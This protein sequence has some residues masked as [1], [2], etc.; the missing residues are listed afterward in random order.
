MKL[1]SKKPNTCA[2]GMGHLPRA[3][4]GG[5]SL[6]ELMVSIVIGLL[7]V[8]FATRIMTD[9]ERTKDAAVGA[10]DSMQ[11]GMLA[12]FTITT[13]AEQAGFGLNDALLTGCDTAFT[14]SMGFEMTSVS[15]NGKTTQPLAAAVIEQG[16]GA[17]SD[18]LTLY[19]G[20]AA[21]G[22]PI[23]RL[24][25][26]YT[27]NSRIDLDRT[28][29]GFYQGDVIVVASEVLDLKEEGDIRPKCSIS[30]IASKPE[31]NSFIQIG[32]GG[33]RFTNGKLPVQ[34]SA[35]LGRVFNL[36]PGSRLAFHT[37]SAEG[38][39]LR[40]RATDLAGSA[41]ESKPVAD[42]IVAL[43]AQY[44]F[45]TREQEVFDR[46]DGPVVTAW[47]A[48]MID[49]DKNGNV[50]GPGDYTR[51]AALR[52]GLVARSKN[53][54]RPAAD[55]TCNATTAA[56][57]L[58]EASQPRNVAAVPVTTSLA[59]A[60]DTVDW[61]CYRYRVFETIVPLRNTGWRSS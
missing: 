27:G 8:L 28:A 57:K 20:S 58:F 22:T 61:K 13:D 45:D 30:Q 23:A 19:S 43:K 55:G 25:E 54:E 44:G 38:G 35:N 48:T 12:L 53:P 5:F 37:W 36:G 42:N 18:R 16:V 7:A 59:V 11:N 50:G 33:F 46:S 47:S 39:Y 32:G 17:A 9:N 24:K 60:G 6:V 29:Y 4:S 41:A 21:G 49:A 15:A 3:R 1:L 14:D 31:S 2:D 40:L 10:S 52:I 51:I 26:N 34:Y 56:P